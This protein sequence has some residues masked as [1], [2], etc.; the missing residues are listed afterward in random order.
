MIFGGLLLVIVL[1]YYFTAVSRTVLFWGAFILTRPLGAVVGDFL[2]KPV[3]HGGLAMSRYGASIALVMFIVV[4]GF[5][6]KQRP[7]RVAH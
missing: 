2:D 1:L 4:C 5:L 3:A 6:F 7:A